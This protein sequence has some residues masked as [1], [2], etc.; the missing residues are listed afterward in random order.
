MKKLQL[1][2][3]GI[4]LMSVVSVS[5]Q[6]VEG[7]VFN[8]KTEEPIKGSEVTFLDKED[9]KLLSLYSNEQGG[10]SFDATK[11]DDVYKIITS[12]K[13][14]N[15]AEVLIS[16][17]EIGL[18]ANFGLMKCDDDDSVKYSISYSKGTLFKTGTTKKASDNTKATSN[19][20][21]TNGTQSSNT[22]VPEVNRSSNG[23]GVSTSLPYFY[24][25][26]NSSY[27]TDA[28]KQTLDKIVSFMKNSDQAKVRVHVYLESRSNVKYNEWMSE[29]R[30]DRA[31]EYI[32]SQGISAS[33]LTKWVEKVY[34]NVSSKDGVN[35]GGTETRR[36]DFEVM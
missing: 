36:C 33:R 9:N 19:V 26:F 25:D 16:E 32:V 10:Y 1:I 35:R 28:N 29:R 21:Q 11:L 13:N 7:K 27:L 15:T 23:V 31:I 30:A 4:A 20:A 8:L 34:G 5:A 18:N 2:T 24:Y 12:A 6:R 22:R 14:Y 3:F 17:I